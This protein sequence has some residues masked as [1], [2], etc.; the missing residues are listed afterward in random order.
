MPPSSDTCHQPVDLVGLPKCRRMPAAFVATPLLMNTFQAA[1]Y[2]GLVLLTVVLL[3]G[4][5]SIH[6]AKDTGNR[7]P[8]EWAEWKAKRL[9]SVGNPFGWTSLSGLHWLPEGTSWIGSS[10]SN[11]IVL[12]P[13]TVPPSLGRFDRSGTRVQFTPHPMAQ[14]TV[15]GTLHDSVTLVSDTPGPASVIETG[16]V[17]IVLI[18]RGE[19]GERLGLRVRDPNAPSRQ[20]FKELQYFPYDPKWR[21]DARWEPH[22][23][24]QARR[25]ADVTGGI[26]LMTSPG[27]VVFEVNGIEYRLDAVEDLEEKDL[28]ILFRDQTAGKS[29]YGSGRFVH[30]QLPDAAGKLVLDFNFAY[31][32]PCA[33]T[34]F[35]TCPIPSRQNHLPLRIEAGEKGYAAG[36]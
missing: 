19:F 29:T 11:Q 33:F 13:K 22:T 2:C 12:I 21:F 8:T 16:G 9:K 5:G 35:A 1:V 30:A 28:F 7:P 34:P 25:F 4:C 3:A 6:P 36:H 31:T 10:P 15:D 32:P 23:S 17:R 26:E 14:C 24:P 20:H 18:Q 27:T